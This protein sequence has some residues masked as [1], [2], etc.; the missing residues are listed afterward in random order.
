MLKKSSSLFQWIITAIAVF[1]SHTA[2]AQLGG[3]YTIDASKSASSTNY[4]SFSAAISDLSKGSRTDGGTPNGA[5]VKGSVVFIVASG[6]YNEQLVIPTINGVSAT[7]TITFDGGVGNAASRVITYAATDSTKPYTIQLAATK[8][9]RFLHL[10]VNCTGKKWGWAFHLYNNGNPADSNL[11]RGCVMNLPTTPKASYLYSFMGIVSSSSTL[12]APFNK[13][14]YATLN[15]LQLDSNVINGGKYALYHSY[16]I[17]NGK[18]L[19]NFIITNNTFT[20][21]QDTAIFL[22]GASA[23]ILKNNI[24]KLDTSHA[25]TTGVCLNSLDSVDIENNDIINVRTYGLYSLSVSNNLSKATNRLLNNVISSSVYS[26]PYSKGICLVSSYQW[27]I[28]HNTVYMDG[29]FAGDRSA[30]VS[31]DNSNS[32]QKYY[33]IRN[34]QFVVALGKKNTYA[35]LIS[36]T[37]H[38][39]FFDYNNFYNDPG[40]N[41]GVIFIKTPI[42]RKRLLGYSGLNK[43]SYFINPSFTSTSDFT[44]QNGCLKGTYISLAGSDKNGKTRSS[45]PE[46]GAIEITNSPNKDDIGVISVSGPVAPFSNGSYDIK[47]LIKNFGNNTVSSADIYYSV[48]GTPQKTSWT[49]TLQPCDSLVYTFTGSKQ[50]NFSA[51]GVL[52]FTAYTALPNGNK[53]SH[54]D[55]DTAV[56]YFSPALSGSYTINNTSKGAADFNNFTEAANTLNIAGVSGSV[57]FNVVSSTY[58]ERFILASI[59]G[60][61]SSNNVVFQG[62]DKDSTKDT[63]IWKTYNYYDG[64]DNS[65][66][67]RLDGVNNVS[68]KYIT[69]NMNIGGG[70]GVEL[71]NDCKSISLQSNTFCH[72]SIYN[73][74]TFVHEVSGNDSAINIRNNT[75]L[76]GGTGVN[77]FGG[78]YCVI[79]HNTFEKQYSYGITCS[80]TNNL[81]VTSNFITGG[82]NSYYYNGIYLYSCNTGMLV[83]KNEIQANGVGSYGLYMNICMGSFSE[84]DQVINNS[85]IAGASGNWQ[86]ISKA[87]PVYCSQGIRCNFYNNSFLN[88]STDTTDKNF[89]YAAVFG[90]YTFSLNIRNN[91]IANIG[92]GK[93]AGR[94]LQVTNFTQSTC[95]NNDIYTANTKSIL[96]ETTNPVAHFSDLTSWQ[97]ATKIDTGSISV[98]PEIAFA[99]DPHPLNIALSGRG[100]K[101]TMV[102]DDLYGKIRPSTPAIGA[103][104]PKVYANDGAIYGLE[105]PLYD[106]CSGSKSILVHIKNLGTADLK[107]ADVNWKVDDSA[108][109]T[110]SYSWKGNLKTLQVADSVNIGSYTYRGGKINMKIWISNPNGFTDS[111]HIYDTIYDKTN[112]YKAPKAVI[113]GPNA[114]CTG[115]TE[116]FIAT[117]E[118]AGEIFV[119]YTQGKAT[120]LS[121]S[122]SDTLVV[123]F[124]SKAETDTVHLFVLSS[125]C[126]DQIFKIVHVNNPPKASIS[127]NNNLCQGNIET[128][129]APYDSVSRYTW[130]AN[131][132]TILSGQSS[133]SITVQWDS[134]GI[135]NIKLSISNGADCNDSVIKS[136]TIHTRPKSNFSFYNQCFGDSTYFIDSS[137]NASIYVWSF[138]DGDSALTANP[139]HK[140]A[141]AGTYSVVLATT[142]SAGCVDSLKRSI[143]VSSKPVAR[144]TAI[145]GCAGHSIAFIDSSI[146]AANYIWHFGDGGLSTFSTPNHVYAKSGKYKVTLSLISLSGCTD[147][148]TDTIVIDASPK[149]NFAM[150]GRCIA[151]TTVF[152]D[153]SLNATNYKWVFGDGDSSISANPRHKYAIAGKYKVKLMVGN[154]S[155]CIDSFTQY[156]IIDSTCVWP[157]DANGDKVVDANDVLSIGIAY[158]DTGSSRGDTST[159][160]MAHFCADWSGSFASGK[161]YKH[162]DCNGDGVVDST[163]TIAVT[164]NYSLTHAKTEETEQGSPTDPDFKLVFA[165]KTFAEGDTLRADVYLGTAAK[166]IKN[167]YGIVFKVDYNAS[168]IDPSLIATDFANSWFGKKGKDLLSYR[169]NK[170]NAGSMDVALVRTDHNNV[171]GYG[172]IG[173]IEMLVKKNI[174]NRETPF[175]FNISANKLISYNQ[176]IIPVY[177]TSDTTVIKQKTALNEQLVSENNEISIFP[178]PFSVSTV[179]QYAIAKEEMVS[180]SVIDMNGRQLAVLINGSQQPAGTHQVIFDAQKYGMA[181]GVYFIKMVAPDKTALKKL[182]LAK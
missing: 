96:A 174:P 69:F 85:I 144:W 81:A 4:K 121:G 80:N 155:G 141:K 38:I 175:A 8:H 164:R 27:Q 11:I 44:P 41:D 63:L 118:R 88:E 116:S 22:E 168:L 99:T 145:G 3:T 152:I 21:C 134:S 140:Y 136:I 161:N 107:T 129:A 43:H 7:N 56:S 34:N 114:V 108:G 113:N 124:P 32:Y 24:I 35:F 142:S 25:S 72:D 74:G 70:N 119:W 157:G 12:A 52:K 149:A 179:I 90:G 17:L 159:T 151:D 6:T 94:A 68:F 131:K 49:G 123:Q 102:K 47:V 100:K 39:K 127:G 97:K 83:S 57:T 87:M 158:T 120:I 111:S 5:G 160:W 178:N 71:V 143:T 79:D 130:I 58:R 153:S 135:G 139:V 138:G 67:V 29:S 181:P 76:Y 84:F 2:H 18:G 126:S 73:N 150:Y 31:I 95:G 112:F 62:K 15:A 82:S 42:N 180:L 156:I 171:S 28:W 117:K 51:V 59:P 54:A 166:P 60:V 75:F 93:V 48:N 128:Y 147:S 98:D 91:V 61:S 132:G 45:T 167:A 137:L 106:F 89:N 26:Y 30:A 78:Q 23:L 182:I 19:G 104:E 9:I 50:Y 110:G 133:D 169:L 14:I 115:S 64:T 55:N 36:D 105:R 176:A 40:L 154:T 53:D 33:D 122:R 170:Y 66:L 92:N 109:T 86:R 146:G 172:K 10:T 125:P 173:T 20:S 77:F 103:I 162:A 177:Y 148:L 1:L 37:A 165:N 46:I 163:D 13:N 16:Y 65:Y 101:F